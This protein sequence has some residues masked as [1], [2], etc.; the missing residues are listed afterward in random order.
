MQLVTPLTKT[1]GSVVSDAPG[2]CGM[3]RPSNRRVHFGQAMDVGS[4]RSVRRKLLARA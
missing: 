3:L 1:H 2:N 4:D